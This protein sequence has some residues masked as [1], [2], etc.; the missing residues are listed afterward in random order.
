MRAT[1]PQIL[2]AIKKVLRE[3]IVIRSQSELFEKVRKKLSDKE[4]VQITAERIRRVAKKYGVKVQVHSRKGK[5]IKNCPFCGKELQDIL[6]K[7]LFGRS[8]TIGKICK[9]CKFEIGLG[10]SPARYIFRR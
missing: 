9:V 2:D 4:E 1:D 8:T 6:S 3:D 5:D 10:R 7:D